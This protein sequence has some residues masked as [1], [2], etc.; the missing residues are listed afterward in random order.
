VVPFEPET[1]PSRLLLA[2]TLNHRAIN[3]ATVEPYDTFRLVATPRNALGEPLTGLPAP[4]F[5]STDTTAVWVTPDG[6]LHARRAVGAVQVIASVVANGIRREDTAYVNVTARSE[7]PQLTTFSIAPQ[8]AEEGTWPIL[9]QMNEVAGVGAAILAVVGIRPH[10]PGFPLRAL[11]T[12][13]DP[14]PGL[15]VEYQS[16]D[17]E[18]LSVDRRSGQAQPRRPGQARVAAHTVAYGV[19]RADTAIFTVTVPV[20]HGVT[21]TGRGDGALMLEPTE[22]RILENGYVFWANTTTTPVDIRFEDPANV[23]NIPQICLL[24]GGIACDPGEISAFAAD[25]TTNPLLSRLRARRFS[26]AG[27][28][29]YESSLTGLSGR[30]VV[31]PRDADSTE[32]EDQP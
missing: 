5:R 18:I 3:L 8:T 11:D 23:D 12:N 9:P 22:V 27:V 7:A 6:V 19:A 10:P 13:G 17:P 1:D 26:Q 24:L 28:Y 21:I 15:V 31:L 32:Q 29:E 20:V 4:T 16:L 30:V 25:N 14:V 2:L